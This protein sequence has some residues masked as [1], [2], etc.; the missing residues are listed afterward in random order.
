[1]K[2]LDALLAIGPVGSKITAEAVTALARGKNPPLFLEIGSSEA[3]EQQNPVYQS[4]EIP[5]GAFGGS[6]PAEGGPLPPLRP[7]GGEG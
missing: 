2:L 7:G 1:M 4:A 3:I 6:G 5:A